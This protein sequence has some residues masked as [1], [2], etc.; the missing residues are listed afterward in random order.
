MT[1]IPFIPYLCL[2]AGRF[3]CLDRVL[4]D[5]FRNMVTSPAIMLLD[6]PMHGSLASPLTTVFV[7]DH[8]FG[9]AVF[10]LPNLGLSSR[11]LL[12]YD[13]R[14][15]VSYSFARFARTTSLPSRPAHSQRL[16]ARSGTGSPLALRV[17][18]RISSDSLYANRSACCPF[19]P[20]GRKRS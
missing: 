1:H 8:R 15:I 14:G 18:P 17:L 20:F 2:S 12:I 10:A 7:S 3:G 11:S 16:V 9:L 5:V 13:E 6:R 4:P 19:Q